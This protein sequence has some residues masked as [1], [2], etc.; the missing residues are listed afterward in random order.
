MGHSDARMGRSAMLFL[1]AKV[2]EGLIGVWTRTTMK[3][4]ELR[5]VQ[6]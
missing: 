6:P 5:L 2:L 4:R 3:P 1:P